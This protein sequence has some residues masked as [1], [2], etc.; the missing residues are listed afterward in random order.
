MKLYKQ[1]ENNS[2]KNGRKKRTNFDDGAAIDDMVEN[3][4]PIA[5]SSS[6]RAVVDKKGTQ[7]EERRRRGPHQVTLRKFTAKDKY[8]I[9]GSLVTI[10]AYSGQNDVLKGRT[11]IVVGDGVVQGKGRKI[12]V[13]FLV[14]GKLQSYMKRISISKLLWHDKVYGIELRSKV[15]VENA[16]LNTLD[17]LTMHYCRDAVVQ[18]LCNSG[19]SL[20]LS[21]LKVNNETIDMLVKV[22]EDFLNRGANDEDDGDEENLQNK[23]SNDLKNV[24][25]KI[26]SQREGE[27]KAATKKAPPRFIPNPEH[28]AMLTAMGFLADQARYALRALRMICNEQP[29]F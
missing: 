16:L 2:S 4:A 26:N 18:M 9:P 25:A 6:Q 20:Q 3:E 17:S 19:K 5:D 14:P 28:L 22:R 10:D 7:I 11:G 21:E 1:N 8:V 15:D 23:D 13:K 27:I 12:C 24:D 29:H